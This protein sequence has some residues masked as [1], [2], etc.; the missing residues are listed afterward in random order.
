MST[1]IPEPSFLIEFEPKLNN[2]DPTINGNVVNINT[3]SGKQ[4][5]TNIQLQVS[6]TQHILTIKNNN[7][8]VST[9]DNVYLL[10]FELS[11]YVI[12]QE[13]GGTIKLTATNNA[14]HIYDLNSPLCDLFQEGDIVRVTMFNDS[15]S[16]NNN[17]PLFVG[18]I[19]NIEIFYSRAGFEIDLKIEGLL[20]ILSRSATIQTSAQQTQNNVFLTPIVANQNINFN[21][22]LT[23]L[24][25]ETII[26][27]TITNIVYNA[28]VTNGVKE[29][30][31]IGG[32]GTAICQDSNIFI[33]SPPTTSKLDVIL[34]TLY[35]YQRVFYVDN[36]GNFIITPL[37][38]YFDTT[39]NWTFQMSSEVITT[40]STVPLQ[41]ISINKNSSN[42]QNR[43]FMSLMGIFNQFIQSDITGSNN[44]T[45]VYAVATIN[46]SIF[47]RITEFVKSGQYLQ[48]NFAVQE[49]NKNIVTNSGFLNIAKNF[50][51]LQG[52]KSIISVNDNS[53]TIK[54]KNNITNETESLKY[55][56]KLYSAKSLAEQLF[57][58]MKVTAVM[59]T[60]LTY[61]TATNSFR[62]I[63]LNQMVTI[64]TVTNNNF[65]GLTQLYCYGY[66][67]SYNRSN[68]SMTTLH[69]CK[70]YTFTALWCDSV[71]ELSKNQATG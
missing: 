17:V 38:T 8:I 57:N 28:G 32:N 44:T 56:I 39:N 48:T 69:L 62:Q 43:T 66:T 14:Q 51:N 20:N 36:S 31:A 10:Q 67:I 1:Y 52:L 61:N 15:N 21:N 54:L 47:P 18:S 29:I 26:A 22:F 23:I 45:G 59:P 41:A 13:A 19:N 25:N 40:G 50:K 2:G 46:N 42:V 58:D 9:T 65:D 7:Q 53:L 37:Q 3:N 12:N 55:F 11:N 64:P 27:E 4:S 30:N 33:F 24:L 71:V 34:Q 16:T 70:P 60:N 6:G 63:P 35:A 68:G 5:V 49:L